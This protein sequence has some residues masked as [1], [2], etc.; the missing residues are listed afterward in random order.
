MCDR[1][2]DASC[3]VPSVWAA[4]FGS[5]HIVPDEIGGMSKVSSCPECSMWFQLEETGSYVSKLYN[6]FLW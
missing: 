5:S 6:W 1:V 3:Q 4:S 2:F